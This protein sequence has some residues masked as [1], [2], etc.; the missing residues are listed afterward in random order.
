[1]TNNPH[2]TAVNSALPHIGAKLSVFWGSAEFSRYM[3]TLF[4]DTRNDSRK[5]F[6]FAVLLA[7]TSLSDEHDREYPQFAVTNDAWTS[8]RKF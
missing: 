1:M 6:P 7:L 8:T 2:F 5:G 4:H 3:N